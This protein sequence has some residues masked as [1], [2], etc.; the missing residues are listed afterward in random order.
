[1]LA[2]TKLRKHQFF[3]KFYDCSRKGYTAYHVELL[4][5]LNVP[6]ANYP[7]QPEFFLHPKTGI[8]T[9]FIQANTKFQTGS[10]HALEIK[11]IKY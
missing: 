5:L 9:W 11:Y 6:A 1:M 3:G 7:I 8:Q 2:N 10:F 4:I